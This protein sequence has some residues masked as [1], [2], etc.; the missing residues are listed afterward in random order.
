MN[1]STKPYFDACP[2]ERNLWGLC[3]FL[4]D[5]KDFNLRQYKT[6][7]GHQTLQLPSQPACRDVP[8]GPISSKYSSGQGQG[9]SCLE[10]WGTM[11]FSGSEIGSAI[12]P[13]E[14]V[15]RE[16]LK[17]H[18]ISKQGPRDLLCEG[19]D[20]TSWESVEQGDTTPG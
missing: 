14:A 8:Q 11:C 4:R 17:H 18:F 10:C 6:A 15:P 16:L 20:G 12:S 2:G 9:A 7:T 1:I 13:R 3:P 5:V 19:R